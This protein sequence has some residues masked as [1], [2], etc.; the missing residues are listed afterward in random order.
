MTPPPWLQNAFLKLSD[1]IFLHYPQPIPGK[2]KLCHCKLISHRGDYDNR[3]VIEN[4]LAAFDRIEGTGVWGI[5]FDIRW[6][7]DLHPIVFH[8]RNLSRL[9]GVNQ[10]VSRLDLAELKTS[11]PL[12]PTLEE[13][14]ARYGQKLHLMIEIKAESY[15]DPVYQNRVLNEI[16]APL[17]PLDDYHLIS[18]DPDMFQQIDFLSNNAFLPIAEINVANISKLAIKEKYRGLLGHY[19]LIGNTCLRRHHQN[20]QMIGT[21][22]VNSKNCFFRELNRGVTWIFSQNALALQ[23]VRDRLLSEN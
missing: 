9:L 7:K 3:Q 11:F 15:P 14:I 20:D 4:T 21:G 8:D 17:E 12:I 18:L 16:L 22:F 6:T 13:M 2:E 19:L 1:T 5:E 23:I 10:E